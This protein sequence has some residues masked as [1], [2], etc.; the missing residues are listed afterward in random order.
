MRE[1]EDETT[2]ENTLKILRKMERKDRKKRVL[3]ELDKDLDIRDQ[4]LGI[5][6]LKST[7]TPR[8]FCRKDEK[9]NH[10]PM[11]KRAEEAASYLDKTQWGQQEDKSEEKVAEN[12]VSKQ[13]NF[14]LKHEPISQP[15][16]VIPKFYKAYSYSPL[17]MQSDPHPAKVIYSLPANPAT[18][19]LKRFTTIFSSNK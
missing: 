15:S 12:L 1:G 4:C 17:P 9:G 3:D 5:K 8:S 10:I 16:E 18:K 6:R 2:E 14:I 13:E 7:Y 11:N 19:D